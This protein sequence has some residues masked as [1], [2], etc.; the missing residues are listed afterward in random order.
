MRHAARSVLVASFLVLP[1]LAVPA[2]ARN[3][4]GAGVE[5]TLANAP[6]D[7]ASFRIE[8]GARATLQALW[9]ASV[10]AHQERVACIGGYRGTHVAHITRVKILTSAAADSSNVS[11]QASLA[12]CG[13]PEWFG[14]VHTHIARFQGRPFS[15]FSPA[16]RWVM[17]TWRKTWRDEGVFCVLYSETMSHCEAGGE[18]SGDPAYA[19][20]VG[21]RILP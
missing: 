19:A 9:H 5:P 16:D 18:A 14:T 6:L 4:A 11:A 2:D 15:T 8:M 3:R 1:L 21:N 20:V 7:D 17:A 10:G 12:E 13:T